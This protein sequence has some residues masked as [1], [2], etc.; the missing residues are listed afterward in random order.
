MALAYYI[1][2]ETKMY[3]AENIMQSV[4]KSSNSYLAMNIG[5]VLGRGRWRK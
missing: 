2:P 4:G 5:F 1:V 3:D